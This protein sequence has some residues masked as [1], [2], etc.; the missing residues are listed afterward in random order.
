MFF[1]VTGIAELYD[2]IWPFVIIV[3][4]NFFGGFAGAFV[5]DDYVLFG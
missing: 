5:Y 4:I 2:F 1:S 3:V